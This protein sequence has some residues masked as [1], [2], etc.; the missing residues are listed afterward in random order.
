VCCFQQENFQLG[1]ANISWA[2]KNLFQRGAISIAQGDKSV[3]VRAA[4]RDANNEWFDALTKT[5]DNINCMSRNGLALL[6]LLKLIRRIPSVP[7]DCP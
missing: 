2:K 5:S 1:S 7:V 4:S 3:K 6:A